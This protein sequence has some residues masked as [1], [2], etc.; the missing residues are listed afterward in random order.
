MAVAVV[1]FQAREKFL[2]EFRQAFE[3]EQ[4][5]KGETGQ[6]GGEFGHGC[7]LVMTLRRW[8]KGRNEGGSYYK[9]L[10]GG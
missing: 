10:D 1:A 2:V 4:V 3:T 8:P 6:T 9:V 7:W 5:R